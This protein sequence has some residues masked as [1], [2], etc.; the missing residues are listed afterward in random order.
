M[1]ELNRSQYRLFDFTY[2][3]TLTVLRNK[4]SN[5]HCQSFLDLIKSLKLNIIIKNQRIINAANLF[6]FHF[7]KLSFPDCLLMAAAKAKK[8]QIL[9]FDKGLQKA[10]QQIA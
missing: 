8:A 10:W 6:F 3:E 4:A 7:K 1:S 9:T 2:T 5:K